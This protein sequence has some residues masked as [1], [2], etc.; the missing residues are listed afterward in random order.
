MT[1]VT[2]PG[3]ARAYVLT[4]PFASSLRLA[5]T[6]GGNHKSFGVP[7]NTPSKHPVGVSELDEFARRQWES[8]LG[9]MVGSTGIDV[10][11][12][13]VKLSQGVK[14]LLQAGGLVQVRGRKAE[15]TKEGFAFILQ[16]VNAQ[17]W[18]VLIYYLDNAENVRQ[19]PFRTTPAL[20]RAG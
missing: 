19:V 16:E 8:V 14:T 2:Q 1:I 3:K 9:Y 4:N 11:D 18:T 5:L 17:V 12:E 13:G 6:G 10:G 7:C 15:I 20:L